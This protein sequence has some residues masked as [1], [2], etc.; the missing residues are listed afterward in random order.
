MIDEKSKWERTNRPGFSLVEVVF[1]SVVAIVLLGVFW[2]IYYSQTSTAHKLTKKNDA[3]RSAQLASEV[4]QKDLKQLVSVEIVRNEDGTIKRLYG[5]HTAPAKVSP[6]GKSI[7]F[8]IPAETAGSQAPTDSEGYKECYTVVYSMIPAAKAGTYGIKRSILKS[9]EDVV[10]IENGVADEIPGKLINSVLVR[11]VTFHLLDP[12]APAPVY[13]SPD[14]NYYLQTVI[15]GTDETGEETMN[16]NLLTTLEYPSIMQMTQNIQQV[17]RYRAIA[18]LVTSPDTFVPTPK[19][20]QAIAKINNIT[21]QFA[22]GAIT[23]TEFEDKITALINEH[24]GQTN[25]PVIGSSGNIIPHID[26]L[27]LAGPVDPGQPIILSTPAGQ[28]VIVP[29][30]ATKAPAASPDVTV[31][32]GGNDWHFTAQVMVL[33]SNGNVRYQENAEG[34]GTSNNVNINDLG[35]MVNNT[36]SN[37]TSNAYGYIDKT[38]GNSNVGNR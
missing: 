24:A 8:Y 28:A 23:G 31:S 32:E 12:K 20:K 3:L 18:P 7:S 14:T 33:D 22:N 17:T 19:E 11:D 30:P 9:P 25:G 13:R 15:Q 5:D 6:N 36:V 27:T 35:N 1:G 16:A 26:K 29:P 34:G 21:E 37:L 10:N 2:Q 4:I 38:N